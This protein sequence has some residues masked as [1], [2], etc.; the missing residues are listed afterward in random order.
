MSAPRLRFAMIPS[1][2]DGVFLD[3]GP[4]AEAMA[5]VQAGTDEEAWARAAFGAERV[6]PY[7]LSG[8]APTPQ[9]RLEG[10][11]IGEALRTHGVG[12]LLLSA[13]CAPG[14]RDWAAREGVRLL[15]S[16]YAHQRRLEHKGRFDRFLRTHGLPVPARARLDWRSLRVAPLPA[17]VQQVESLGGEGTFFV[18]R[19]E[20]LT[21]LVGA[22]RVA[23]GE[24][25]L[26]RQLVPGDPFGITVFVA[27]GV[28]ALSAI[29]RQC[30]FPAGTQQDGLAFAGVQWVPA[31]AL[32][33]R[34]RAIL[35]AV[36]HRVGRLLH[37]GRFFGFGNLDFMLGD[38]DEPAILECNP[39]MSAATP[40]LL[41]H[42]ELGGGVPMG[43]LFL[44]G[45]RGPRRYPSTPICQPLPMSTFAGATLELVAPDAL[46]AV[47]AE[48]LPRNG[49][50]A[51]T[52]ETAPRWMGSAE[53]PGAA[54]VLFRQVEPG[55]SVGRGESLATVLS[56][57]PL[58]DA[59]GRLLPA[60]ARRLTEAWGTHVD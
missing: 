30:Y 47:S 48:V 25:L 43:R 55:A 12:A 58:Y 14:T 4:G 18:R 42:P 26:C 1:G 34:R 5:L 53:Q 60:A 59:D 24:R 7:R 3:G 10:S 38:D 57:R 17:V 35:E 50:Y 22:G 39:R 52:G 28:V 49:C 45:F 16:D 31:D 13:P 40:Q 54:L 20:D 41:R 8:A 21:A 46:D 37:A 15:M 33:T 32:S 2:I 9:A 44:D 29:R 36:F 27:P 23:R 51:W 11:D 6:I 19:P 56:E